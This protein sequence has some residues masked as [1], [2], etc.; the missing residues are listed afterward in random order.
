M[1]EDNLIKR[2]TDI[3]IEKTVNQR[4]PTVVFLSDIDCFTSE[5]II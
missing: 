5:I 3:V 1:I 4:I 2:I